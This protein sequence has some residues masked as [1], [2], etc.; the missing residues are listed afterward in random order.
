[1]K[2]QS[3]TDERRKAF[4][5]KYTRHKAKYSDPAAR[6]ESGASAT[7]RDYFLNTQRERELTTDR[8]NKI[9]FHRNEATIHQALAD[10]P[11][12]KE[13]FVRTAFENRID[14][15]TRSKDIAL[16]LDDYKVKLLRD[17]LAH[18]NQPEKDN[19]LIDKATG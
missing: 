19:M 3:W 14:P 10:H 1:M 6:P 17:S 4:E 8:N 18:A 9:L 16:M 2:C 11:F 7:E 5:E 15:I 13:A 12:L